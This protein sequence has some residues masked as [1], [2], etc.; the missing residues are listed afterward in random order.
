M[1][2]IYDLY[3]K[4]G[5]G[6][7]LAGLTAWGMLNAVTEMVDHHTG[8]KTTDARMDSAWFGTG[9]ALKQRA[10]DQAMLLAA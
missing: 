2:L 8:H 6:H 5:M 7:E 4:D 9:A 10:Y 3:T 1:K